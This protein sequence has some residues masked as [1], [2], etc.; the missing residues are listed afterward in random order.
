MKA[1]SAVQ[2][3]KLFV[4]VPPA[5]FD[6]AD[7]PSTTSDNYECGRRVSLVGLCSSKK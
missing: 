6:A 7:T 2:A 4:V 3:I 5:V 1:S